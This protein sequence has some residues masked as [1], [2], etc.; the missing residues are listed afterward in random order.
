VS[1]SQIIIDNILLT[2][3]GA[4]VTATALSVYLGKLL[5]DRSL[6]REKSALEAE[7]LSLGNSHDS[8]M[9][10]LEKDLQLEILRKDHFHQISKTTYQSI[11]ESKI[12]IYSSLLNFKVEFNKLYDESHITATQDPTDDFRSLF[13]RCREMLE[14]NKL[15]ISKELADKFDRWRKKASPL[16]KLADIEGYHANGMAYTEKDNQYNIWEAQLP[17]FSQMIHETMPEMEEILEQIDIF[18]KKIY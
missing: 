3:G 2:F 5:A 16:L 11:F 7:I 18:Y 14:F 17:I 6:L 4:G 13:M 8:K 1:V 9:K 10:L 12:K 15:Y